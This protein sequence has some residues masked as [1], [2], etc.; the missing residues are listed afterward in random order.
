M[1]EIKKGVFKVE[2]N[3]DVLIV[4]LSKEFFEKESIMQAIYDYSHNFFIEMKPFDEHS[5]AVSFTK[6]DEIFDKDLIYSF[7]NKVVDYQ[8]K[9]FLEKDYGRIRDVIVD[10][11]YSPVK[12]N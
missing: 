8:L 4:K 3:D 11:A 12:K 9:R 6:K 5:V 1:I 2:E 7:S 10:Y